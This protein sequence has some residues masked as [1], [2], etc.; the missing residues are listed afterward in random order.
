MDEIRTIQLE[1]T[2]NEAEVLRRIIQ[3]HNPSIQD[4]MVALKLYAMITRKLEELDG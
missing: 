1:L 3:N 4:E 2:I